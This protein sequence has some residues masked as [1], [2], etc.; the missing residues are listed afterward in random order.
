MDVSVHW[1]QGRNA[2][3][4]LLRERVNEVT[5]GLQGRND[6]KTSPRPTPVR[7]AKAKLLPIL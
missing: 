5:E 4:A 6:S 7:L 2:R 1:D 3:K